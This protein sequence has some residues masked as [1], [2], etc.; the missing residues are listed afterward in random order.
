MWLLADA[1]GEKRIELLL[2]VAMQADGTLAEFD[3]VDLRIGQ[4]IPWQQSWGW[5]SE[6]VDADLVRDAVRLAARLLRNAG[7]RCSLVSRLDH[8]SLLFNLCC[9]GWRVLPLLSGVSLG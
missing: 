3:P 2:N 7:V 1:F 8:L 4:G 5:L 9:P 6:T